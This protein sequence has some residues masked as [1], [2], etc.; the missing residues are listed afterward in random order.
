MLEGRSS[1]RHRRTKSGCQAIRSEPSILKTRK[2]TLLCKKKEMSL[3][4]KESGGRGAREE[5]MC[6]KKT[7]GWGERLKSEA[8]PL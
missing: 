8:G 1:V 7:L 6:E 5:S 4:E 2:T 3:K